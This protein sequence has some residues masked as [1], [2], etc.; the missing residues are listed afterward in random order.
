MEN[1]EM[2]LKELFENG[3]D[4]EYKYSDI[5]LKF[6]DFDIVDSDWNTENIHLVNYKMKIQNV[7]CAFEIIENNIASSACPEISQYF[8]NCKTNIIEYM[9]TILNRND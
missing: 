4:P 3:A 9:G 5:K 6:K 8:D 7:I 2:T 1:N